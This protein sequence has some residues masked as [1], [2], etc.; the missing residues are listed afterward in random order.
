MIETGTIIFDPLLPWPVLWAAM[1]FALVFAGIAV[2][3]GLSGWWLRGL[4]LAVLLLAIAN[5]SLQIED[6]EPLTD[7][8]LLVVDESASQGVAARPD[9]IAA[10]I[11]GVE[12]EIA[13]LDNTELRI[14]RMGDSDGNRGSLLMEALTSAMAD[15]P[16][17]RLAGALLLTDGQVHDMARTPEM[18]APLH[19]LLVPRK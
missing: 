15:E 7:I 11:A 2:W 12:A 9:Q 8:V 17:A 16:R 19:V 13:A 4:A 14:L 1:G 5:P 10:A 6:R 18:P 3:R